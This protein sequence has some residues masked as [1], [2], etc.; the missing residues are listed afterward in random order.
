MPSVVWLPVLQAFTD[1]IT[2][3]AAMRKA[4]KAAISG[5]DDGKKAKKGKKGKK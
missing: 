4:V 3:M 1:V 5:E 2:G